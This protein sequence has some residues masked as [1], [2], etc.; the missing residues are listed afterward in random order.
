MLFIQNLTTVDLFLIAIIGAFAAYNFYLTQHLQKLLPYSSRQASKIKVLSVVA[1]ENIDTSSIEKALY[2]TDIDYNLLPY[3]EVSQESLLAEL[4]KDVTVFELSSHGLNGSFR[5][6]NATIPAT[7]LASVL[8]QYNTLECVLL[9]YCNS[10]QDVELIASTKA[11]TI[12]L[13]GEVE[14][15]SCITFARHFYFFLN[16]QFQYKEAFERARLHLPINDFSKFIFKDGRVDSWNQRKLNYTLINT[17]VEH[18][19]LMVK[20]FHQWFGK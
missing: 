11:F 15:T 1:G 14:D 3:T 8:S 13:V 9:L 20:I 19:L 7:W 18:V 4:D 16:K 2:T 5:L 17:I 6:G 12:G 10:Y